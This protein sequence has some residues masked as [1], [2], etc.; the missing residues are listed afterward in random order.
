MNIDDIRRHNLLLIAEHKSRASIAKIAGYRDA[1][2]INQLCTGHVSFGSRTARKLE[3]S[4]NLAPGWFDSLQ[5]MV[6][7]SNVMRD[8]AHQ[9]VN[10]LTGSRLKILTDF[11][12]TLVDLDKNE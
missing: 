3:A 11:A 10:M 5:P 6:M 2:Y 8:R 12:Q 7:D 1:V 9:L 4:L